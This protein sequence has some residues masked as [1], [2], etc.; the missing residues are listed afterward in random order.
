MQRVVR[1]IL[2]HKTLGPMVVHQRRLCGSPVEYG[3]L[4]RPLPLRL[5]EALTSQGISGLYRHQARGIDLARRG[6]DVLTVTPTASGKTL[7]FALC[8]LESVLEMVG[9]SPAKQVVYLS[10]EPATLCRDLDVLARH[11]YETVSVQ[12]IDMMPQT[13]QVEAL[14]LLRATR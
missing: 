7:I 6:K 8:V 14:A 10:C 13:K 11:G 2:E 4:E 1:Q 12:P 3:E 5:R 9:V